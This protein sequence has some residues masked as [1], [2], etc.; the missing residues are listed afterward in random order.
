MN[1]FPEATSQWVKS[2]VG[3]HS[4]LAEWNALHDQK[5]VGLNPAST[6]V[7]RPWAKC[8]IPSCFSPPRHNN[9]E[10]CY[11]GNHDLSWVRVPV[12]QLRTQ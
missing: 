7:L 9:R 3:E 11:R 6:S 2:F 12:C 4:G 5:V 8:F 1:L 10:Y